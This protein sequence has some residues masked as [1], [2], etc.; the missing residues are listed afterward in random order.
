VFLLGELE[1]GLAHRGDGLG[2]GAPEGLGL[3]AHVFERLPDAG[4]ILHSH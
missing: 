1:D 3:H 4:Q 2:A